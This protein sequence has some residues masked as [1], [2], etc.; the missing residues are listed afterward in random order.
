MNIPVNGFRRRDVKKTQIIAQSIE[1]HILFDFGK[2]ENRLELRAKHQLAVFMPIMQ[3][4]DTQPVAV[5]IKEAFFR[6]PQRDGKHAAQT[7]NKIAAFFFIKMDD[8]FRVRVAI[9]SMPTPDQ[10]LTE[11]GEIIDLSVKNRPNIACF[12]ANRLMPAFKIDNG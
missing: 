8:D 11:L 7:L 2:S 4:F 9:E 10:I 5:K 6:V 1:R 12:I 3:R